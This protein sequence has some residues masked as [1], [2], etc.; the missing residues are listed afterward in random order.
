MKKSK[1]ICGEI[2][3]DKEGEYVV[4]HVMKEN[5]ECFEEKGQYI[6]MKAEIENGECGGRE[7]VRR[8]DIEDQ[9]ILMKAG[10]TNGEYTQ[11]KFIKRLDSVS[12]DETN[13]TYRQGLISSAKR[14]LE[15]FVREC[16][17]IRIEN[18]S[19]DKKELERYANSP[20]SFYEFHG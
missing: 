17:I 1:T 11:E 15:E 8:V 10:I 20:P 13:D 9:Y 18:F 6:F 14:K 16:D 5:G 12:L 4:M 3:L 7:F 2:H 19:P